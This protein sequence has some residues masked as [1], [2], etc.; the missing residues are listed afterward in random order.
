MAQLYA[1]FTDLKNIMQYGSSG[2]QDDLNFD[3]QEEEN[4]PSN[5]L[6]PPIYVIGSKELK[7]DTIVE[8]DRF[9]NPD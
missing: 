8:A 3:D 4:P 9:D 5:P 2:Q 1:I 6:L 7:D